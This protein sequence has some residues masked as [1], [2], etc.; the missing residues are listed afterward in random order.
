MSRLSTNAGVLATVVGACLVLGATL[1]FGRD[2]IASADGRIY[3]CYGATTG[4]L[5]VVADLEECR[6][7]EN[8]IYWNQTGPTGPAGATGATGETGATGRTGQT[9]A[10][11][12]VGAIGPIGPAGLQ[13]ATGAIGPAGPQGLTGA[14]GPA[15]PS[16]STGRT[17]RAGFDDQRFRTR[18]YGRR[19]PADP[20]RDGLDRASRS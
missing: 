3:G 2:G 17:W 10:A 8:P 14:T 16:G 20:G 15:G 6:R 9:G 19:V 11:G 5:G 12:A 13:G 4:E 1:T 7:Y 18:A